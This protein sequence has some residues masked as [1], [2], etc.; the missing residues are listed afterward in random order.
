[1]GSPLKLAKSLVL[2][3][4]LRLDTDPLPPR[5]TIVLL[6]SYFFVVGFQSASMLA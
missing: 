5:S 1:M 6:L 3:A 4:P 2:M